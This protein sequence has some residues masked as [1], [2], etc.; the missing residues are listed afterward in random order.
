MTLKLKLTIAV[1]AQLS[2]AVAFAAPPSVVGNWSILANSAFPGQLIVTTQSGGGNCKAIT[3]TVFANPI[4]GFYCP[5]TGRISFLRKI[6]TTNDTFQVY[7]GNLSNV[8][9]GSPL[10]MSGT[11]TVPTVAG[12]PL[13]EYPFSAAK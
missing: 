8:F 3:G 2:A 1:A 5:T 10:Q 4:T 13:G 6:A 9:A 12:G 7:T 11:F